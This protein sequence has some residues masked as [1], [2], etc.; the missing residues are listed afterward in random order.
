MPRD[1]YLDPYREHIARHGTGF[2]ATLWAARRTQEVRFEV[3]TQMA[4]LAGKRVADIGCSRGDFAA[5]LLE[6]QVEYASF[7]GFDAIAALIDTANARRL[8]RTT[9]VLADAVT[10]PEPLAAADPQVVC[11]SGT[12]NTM[13]LRQAIDLLDNAWDAAR[14]VLLFNF[15]S[16]RAGRG[17]VPQTGPARRLPTLKLLDWALAKSPILTFRQDYMP[18]GHD[19]TVCIRKA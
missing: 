4:F 6:H 12:L 3:F 5:Y 19:A 1:S 11:I 13:T 10:D 2:D 14:E 15:L 17:A 18:H 7:H 8:P 16:D 9:F